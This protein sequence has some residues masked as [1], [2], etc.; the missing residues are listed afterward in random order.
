MVRFVCFRY[1][2][3]P[4]LFTEKV[5][6]CVKSSHDHLY[7]PPP[8]DD[9]H[10]LRFDPYDSVKHEPVREAVLNP[11]VNDVENLKNFAVN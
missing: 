10:C 6:L 11:K 7:D 9:P 8:I 3:N 2:N 1:R 4:E 5:K